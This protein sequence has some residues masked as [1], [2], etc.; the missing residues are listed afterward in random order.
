MLQLIP[1]YVFLPRLDIANDRQMYLAGWPLLLALSIELKL[2]LNERIFALAI[3]ALFLSLITLTVLRNQVYANEIAL[4]E[5]TSLKSPDKARV[6][7]NLGYA[8]LLDHRDADARR[9]FSAALQIDPT[10]SKASNNL[11]QLG[12][13]GNLLPTR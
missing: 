6:H 13:V 2:W 7:N 12:R 4:W 8:Y 10:L 5:D 11:R 3:A 9:E 1:L